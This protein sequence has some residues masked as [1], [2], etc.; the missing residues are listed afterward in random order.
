MMDVADAGMMTGSEGVI[1][2]SPVVFLIVQSWSGRE[3][4][5]KVKGVLPGPPV[6]AFQ[7]TRMSLTVS[8]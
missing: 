5:C 7:V 4:Y 8:G 3:M 6:A 1:V 2:K